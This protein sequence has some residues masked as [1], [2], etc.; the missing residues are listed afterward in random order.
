MSRAT[1][2]LLEKYPK[3]V[4][5][6]EKVLAIKSAEGVKQV[7]FEYGPYVCNISSKETAIYATIGTGEV[8]KLGANAD[9]GTAFEIVAAVLN[10]ISE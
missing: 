6:K 4:T 3:L 10:D 9:F 7:L 2:G 8:V 5:L 1:S